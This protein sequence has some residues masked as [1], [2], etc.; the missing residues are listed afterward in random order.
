MPTELVQ[1]E[2]SEVRWEKKFLYKDN[3]FVKTRELNPKGKPRF[4]VRPDGDFN[5][6][7]HY[8]D[9]QVVQIEMEIKKEEKN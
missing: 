8:D 4:N 7:Y 1:V 9:Y 5:K 3:W 2:F 6:W